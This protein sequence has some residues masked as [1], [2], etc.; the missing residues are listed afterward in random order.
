[1]ARQLQ[2]FVKNLLNYEGKEEIQEPS[3]DDKIEKEFQEM[4]KNFKQFI[5][6]LPKIVRDID[7]NLFYNVMNAQRTKERLVH[8]ARDTRP[9][10][11]KETWDL[12]DD[13][14]DFLKNLPGI[15]GENYSTVYKNLNRY[16]FVKRLLFKRPLVF[17]GRMD[18]YILRH[19]GKKIKEGDNGFYNVAECLNKPQDSGPYL[20][21]YISYDENLMSSLIGMSTPTFYFSIGS[22]RF[23]LNADQPHI[24]EGILCGLVGARNEKPYFME[25]RFVFPGVS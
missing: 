1:M 19:D 13:Y 17:C 3:K 8:M 20:T 12:L 21:E 14:M 2:D 4:K 9:I 18:Y 7:R 23:A 24:D 22:G 11:A 6:P 25:H 5:A 15:E 16:D 10:I